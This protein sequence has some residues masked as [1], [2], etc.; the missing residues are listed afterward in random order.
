MVRNVQQP[1]IKKVDYG[2]TH[3]SLVL[4][5]I[6]SRPFLVPVWSYQHNQIMKKKQK[7]GQDKI[8]HQLLFF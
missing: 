7:N 5:K 4:K 1:R 2:A 3:H 6:K 8:I